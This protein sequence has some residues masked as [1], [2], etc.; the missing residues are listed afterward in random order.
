MLFTA[1]LGPLNP[2][3]AAVIEDELMLCLT[4]DPLLKPISA[5]EINEI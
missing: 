3:T 4:S 5:L 1:E 2:P